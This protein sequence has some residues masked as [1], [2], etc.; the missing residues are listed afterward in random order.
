VSNF[1]RRLVDEA[2]AELGEGR[3]ATNQVEQ[4][5]YLPNATLEA[6]CRDRGIPL[7]AYRPLAGS[8]ATHDPVLTRIARAYGA[9]ANQVALA[10]LL[11]RG[12]IVIPKASS[13]ERQ[14]SNLAAAG[15]WLKAAEIAEIDGLETGRRGIAPSGGP[16]WD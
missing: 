2:I 9:G 8:R 13:P 11:A 12:S 3:I 15:L 6:H 7:T 1:T 14:E 10:W 5:V 16:D 4:H